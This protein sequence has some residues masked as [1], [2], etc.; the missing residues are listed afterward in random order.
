[1]SGILQEYVTT[2]YLRMSGIY[3]CLEA[4]DLMGHLDK[5][6]TEEVAAY[7][8]HCQQPNSGFAPAEQHD[9]HLLHTLSAVQVSI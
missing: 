4:M 3:W 9:V 8:K 7:V 1:M 6:N 2:E 5:I